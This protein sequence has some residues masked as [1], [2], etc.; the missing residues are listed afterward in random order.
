MIIV[1]N[2][3]EVYL[4]HINVHRSCMSYVEAGGNDWIS[5]TD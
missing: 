2:L 5:F 1:M 4:M 3:L